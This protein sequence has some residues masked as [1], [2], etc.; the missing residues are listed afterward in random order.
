MPWLT[1]ALSDIT[2]VADP[3]T[4]FTLEIVQ[5]RL[6]NS[7]TSRFLQP[8]L[9]VINSKLTLSMQLYILNTE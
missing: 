1:T 7:C 9:S 6:K 3:L 2:V 8:L 5:K 4:E